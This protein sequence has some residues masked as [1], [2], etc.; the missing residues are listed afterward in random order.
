MKETDRIRQL[1]KDLFDGDPWLGVNVLST[2]EGI[3]AEKAAVKIA[4]GRN[5]IWEIVNHMTSWRRNVLRRF[6]GKVIPRPEHNYIL[7][8]EIT[9]EEA[10]RESIERLK[11]SQEQWLAF[12]ETADEDSLASI[13]P[14]NQGSY[15]YH[16][17]G[18]LQHDAYHLGQIV[19]LTKLV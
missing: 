19:M 14:G 4:P 10:W 8:V 15:Y 6:D 5:S 2:L 17:H 7:P 12:L 13:Y 3:T 11:E 18:I 9:T 1:F 16:M